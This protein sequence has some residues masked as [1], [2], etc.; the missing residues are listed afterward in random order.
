MEPWTA[1]RNLAAAL[2][3]EPPSVLVKGNSSRASRLTERVVIT[4]GRPGPAAQA[5]AQAAAPQGNRD[6]A[7]GE[8]PAQVPA[9]RPG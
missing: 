4:P 8:T 6:A 5:Q 9:N 7:D 1:Q 2:A 3:L